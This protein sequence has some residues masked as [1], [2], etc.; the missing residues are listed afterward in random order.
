MLQ[1]ARK[2][3]VRL[4]KDESGPN[5]VEWVLLIIVALVVLIGIYM[6]IQWAFDKTKEKQDE[7]NDSAEPAADF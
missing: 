7:F 5:T 6:F 2:F 4:H 3:A 1:R